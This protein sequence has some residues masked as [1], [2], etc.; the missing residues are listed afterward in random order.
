MGKLFKTIIDRLFLSAVPSFRLFYMLTCVL[1]LTGLIFPFSSFAASEKS[2]IIVNTVTDYT[3]VL[4]PDERK[5]LRI[6]SDEIALETN[7]RILYLVLERVSNYQ[8]KQFG[9]IENY[10]NELCREWK[11]RKKQN[12]P[13]LVLFVAEKNQLFINTSCAS[14]KGITPEIKERLFSSVFTPR[15]ND[16]NA[17][18]AFFRLAEALYGIVVNDPAIIKLIETDTYRTTEGNLDAELS[19]RALRGIVGFL[20]FILSLV[21]SGLFVLEGR[22]PLFGEKPEGIIKQVTTGASGFILSFLFGVV[23]YGFLF[24][25]TLVEPRWWGLVLLGVLFSLFEIGIITLLV[26]VLF[27]GMTNELAGNREA[28]VPLYAGLKCKRT[29]TSDSGI[30]NFSGGW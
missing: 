14:E 1:F 9:S 4:T 10:S 11:F 12:D 22:R 27:S 26:N 21:T 24:G 15:Y 29:D 2:L 5:E 23:C 20:L 8:L 7:I 16:G 17:F 30:G 25:I 19:G 3:G 18:E 6:L 13:V 28:Q